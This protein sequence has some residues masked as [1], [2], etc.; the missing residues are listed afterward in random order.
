MLNVR[1]HI[2]Y[3]ECRNIAATKVT[4]VAMGLVCSRILE[5]WI[6]KTFAYSLT[7]NIILIQHSNNVEWNTSSI[8]GPALC[9]RVEHF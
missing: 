6:L 2:L 4:F 9:Y 1:V 3:M 5:H 8:V 7:S